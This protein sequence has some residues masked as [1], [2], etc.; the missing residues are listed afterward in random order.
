MYELL[1]IVY[2]QISF[3]LC[4]NTFAVTQYNCD[5]NFEIYESCAPLN[6]PC[7]E[8]PQLQDQVRPRRHPL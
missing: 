3:S 6:L 2:P 4:P 7:F 5:W 1:M 8:Q